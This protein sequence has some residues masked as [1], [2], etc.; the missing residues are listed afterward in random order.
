M[1]AI[2][3]LQDS[4]TLAVVALARSPRKTQ[5]KEAGVLP[6]SEPENW[7]AEDPAQTIR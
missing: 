1:T 2:S 5:P 6:K 3:D 7:D 4:P